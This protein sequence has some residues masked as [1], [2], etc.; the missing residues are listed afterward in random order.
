MSC[1]RTAPTLALVLVLGCDEGRETS[2][3]EPAAA[4][5]PPAIAAPVPT[6]IAAPDL[7][8]PSDELAAWLR[9]AAVDEHSFARRVLYSWTSQ[10]TATRIARERE[11]FDDAQLPEGPTAYVSRL[12]Y[13][14]S[15]DDA[16][17]RLAKLLLGHPDL[18]RRRYAWVRPWATRMGVVKPYGERLIA[19]TLRADAIVGR[20]D[21]S[22]DQPWRFHDLDEREVPLGRVLAEPQRIAAVLHIRGDGQPHFREYVLCNPAAIA[23]WSLATP[24]IAATIAEDANAVRELA[25]LA[26]HG[27]IPGYADALAFAVDHYVATADNLAAIAAAL[28]ASPQPGRAVRVEPRARF[29]SDAEPGIV[30]VRDVPPRFVVVA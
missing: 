26:E 8:A 17:G 21:P 23:E 19:V 24:E 13:V 30:H 4:V 14:A 29:R 6:V 20:F 16:S 2:A 11:L 12:E 9:D 18:S 22:L 10:Q 1:P 5:A 7:V 3:P 25:A 28:A 27:D 15:R